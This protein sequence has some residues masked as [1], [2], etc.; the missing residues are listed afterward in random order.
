MLCDEMIIRKSP[1][2]KTRTKKP[3]F[4]RENGALSRRTFFD[5][6]K[7]SENTRMYLVEKF[8]LGAKTP[9]KRPLF[10]TA[11]SK[12]RKKIGDRFDNDRQ[13]TSD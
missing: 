4:F 8:A 5:F 6:K 7:S 13:A 9:G 2:A 1:S 3:C 12:K 10:D 11:A